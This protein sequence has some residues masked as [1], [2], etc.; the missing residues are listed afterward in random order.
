MSASEEIITVARWQTIRQSLPKVLELLV[1]LREKSLAEPGCLGYEV[2][3]AVGEADSLLL[4]ER[5]RD[6]AALE[7]HRNSA[8]YRD[9]VQQHILPLLAN[10]RVELLRT[11]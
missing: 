5:Y 8:H 2:F 1:A 4:L 11:R 10:R 6:Q 3:T 9:L 7:A